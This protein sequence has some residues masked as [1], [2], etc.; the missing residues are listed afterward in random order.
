MRENEASTNFGQFYSWGSVVADDE[1]LAY[2]EHNQRSM[3]SWRGYKHGSGAKA[4]TKYCT[5]SAYGKKDDKTQ[6]DPE[7]DAAA[8]YAK[9]HQVAIWDAQWHIPTEK[10]FAELI[11]KCKWT[12]KKNGYQ[13]TGPNGKSIFLPTAGFAGSDV[14]DVGYYWTSTLCTDFPC[15]AYA[16]MFGDGFIGWNNGT[17]YKGYSIRPV[18]SKK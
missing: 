1:A 4:L 17:R 2:E 15:Y 18:K 3:T 16:V 13:V 8:V 12:W 10:E 9:T 14:K 5:D 6:L 7:D 11:E